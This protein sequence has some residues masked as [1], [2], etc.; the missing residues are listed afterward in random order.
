[1]RKKGFFTTMG[2]PSSPVRVNTGG[3]S[4]AILHD[5]LPPGVVSHRAPSMTSSLARTVP[6]VARAGAKRS[7]SRPPPRSATADGRVQLGRSG[8]DVVDTVRVGA[9]STFSAVGLGRR[10]SSSHRTS[11][12]TQ[13]GLRRPLQV[14]GQ[15]L[16]N[17]SVNRRWLYYGPQANLA[18]GGTPPRLLPHFQKIKRGQG[19]S[20]GEH[21]EIFPGAGGQKV[22]KPRCAHLEGRRLSSRSA[23]KPEAPSDRS[24]GL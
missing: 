8:L 2:C 10:S 22:L 20:R 1:M 15:K 19:F 21:K 16:K 13:Q 9:A 3:V 6:M 24:V 7:H 11:I 4:A 14:Q 18:Q 12:M 23:G 17:R 5:S